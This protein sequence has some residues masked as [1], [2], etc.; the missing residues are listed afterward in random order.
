MKEMGRECGTNE[1]GE[2]H[3]LFWWEDLMKR[4]HFEGVSIAGRIILK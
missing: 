1:T 2:V 3:T 4:D